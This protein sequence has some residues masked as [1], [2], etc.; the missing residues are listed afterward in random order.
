VESSVSSSGARRPGFLPRNAFDRL[1]NAISEAGWQLLGPVVESGVIQFRPISGMAALP[2]GVVNRQ[3]P[4]SYRLEQREDQRLFAWNQGPQGL[5]PLCF[6]PEE[7]LWQESQGPD[8]KMQ[9]ES[10]L[11]EATPIA[12]IG[13]RGCDLAALAIQD[14][15]F[16]S[17]TAPDPHYKARREALFLVGVDCAESAETC[18]C[19]S[20]GDGPSLNGGFDIGLAELDAGFL[21][22]G[23]SQRGEALL[24]SL[25]LPLASDPQLAEM[26]EATDR[27]AAAQ[28]R[29]LPSPAVLRRLYDNLAHPDWDQV[30]ERCLSCGNCTAVCPTCFCYSTEYRTA[31]DGTSAVRIRQ[32]DSCFNPAHSSMG[33]FNVRTTIPQRYRQWLTH[34]LAGWQ[35]QF[36]RIGCTGCGRCISW[37]PVGIDLTREVGLVLGEDDFDV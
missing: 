17:S 19:T 31:L 22:W 24:Q 23:G 4:G 29:R 11:A 13:V 18:F 27:A 6:A 7:C 10:G 14:R 32:W 33:R 15:H 28:Q 16:L 5:K 26:N 1:L 35:D 36:G 8:G 21:T 34:K 12:V 37:C 3:Q 20:T 30:G 9:L 2:T 25:A